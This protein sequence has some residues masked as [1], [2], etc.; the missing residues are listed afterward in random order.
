MDQEYLLL[1]SAGPFGFLRLLYTPNAMVI[2]QTMLTFPVVCGI[3]I[4]SVLSLNPSLR[5]TL[6]SLSAPEFW[7]ARVL[8]KE[9]RIG[10]IIGIIAA[11]GV[12]ISKVGAIMMV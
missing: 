10:L 3:T 11:F 6:I 2:A 4:S 12:A 5:E 8:L 9:S 1:S 7:E